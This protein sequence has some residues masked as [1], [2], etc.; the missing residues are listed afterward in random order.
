LGEF[1]SHVVVEQALIEL[2]SRGFGLAS[3]AFG[4]RPGAQGQQ[5]NRLSVPEVG[6]AVGSDKRRG[7]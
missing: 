6:L 5:A 2:I 3:Q 1:V 7:A 4:A